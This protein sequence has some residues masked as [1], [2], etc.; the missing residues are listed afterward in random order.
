[1]DLDKPAIYFI[2]TTSR[3]ANK[4]IVRH[5]Q[6]FL[7]GNNEHRLYYFQRR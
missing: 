1:M 2:I 4:R 6:Q 5:D 7:N 3:I